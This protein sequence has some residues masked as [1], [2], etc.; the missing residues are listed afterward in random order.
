M[1]DYLGDIIYW[2]DDWGHIHFVN[3]KDQG[4]IWYYDDDE[5]GINFNPLLALSPNSDDVPPVIEPF[6]EDSKFGFY[7]NQTSNYL[8]PDSLYG[9]VDIVVKISEY[10][11]TSEW[12]QPAFKTYYWLKK[13][14][15]DTVIFPKTLGQIL[16][17]SYSFYSSVNYYPYADILYK[18]DYWHPSPFWMN[19]D[20]D[21]FQIL[22]NNNG[23]SIIDLSEAQLAFPTEDYPDGDYRI[24]V[25]AWDESGNMDL[26][27]MDITFD[28][29]I[30]DIPATLVGLQTIRC[31]PNP[32]R[33]DV[34][35]ELSKTTAGSE[36]IVIL[37]SD[38]QQIL[39]LDVLNH[40]VVWRTDN[41]NPGIYYYYLK[42]DTELK[43]GKIIVL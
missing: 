6:S 3:I 24:F 2:S 41:I 11:A 8:D 39:T 20:R 7:V 19:W 37:D 27:S 26:D 33:S 28:N 38:G 1:H 15:E 13:L 18:K 17:H 16:N 36:R 10:H 22:T 43:P 23:D 14:P 12:E 9:D 4:E 32:A 25:E 40:R 30:T 5:W 42:G 34:I 31:Y 35:F 21:Y 29:L